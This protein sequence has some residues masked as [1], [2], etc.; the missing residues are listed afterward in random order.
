MSQIPLQHGVFLAPY[1]PNEE[2]PTTWLRRDIELAQHLDKLGFAELWVGE[3]HSGGFEIIASPDLFIAAAA[4]VTRRIRFGTGVMT[5]PYHNPLVV[6]NR[7]AQLDHQTMGRVSFGFGPGLLMSDALMMGIDPEKTRDMLLEAIDV[8]VRLLRGESVTARTDWFNL[9]EARAHL[10]PYSQP[11]EMAVASAG[12]PSGG[13][14][15]GKFGMSML[16]VAASQVGA[17]DVL[18][19]NWKIA[20]EVAAQYGNTMDPAKLR[21]VAPVHIA[22]TREKALENVRHGLDRW[23]RY[24]DM[25]SPNP[26]PKDGRDPVDILIDSGRAVIGTPEDAIAMIERL[27]G[28]QGQFG[29]F[30]AQHVD[31]ADWDQTM[32]SFELYARYVMPHFSGANANRIATYNVMAERVE[33]FKALRR[34]AADKA[35]AQHEAAPRK[36]G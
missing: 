32:K 18:A 10:L 36:V 2:S 25:A 35:F 5:L 22:E 15:A 19:S 4:E 23:V 14:A 31:W 20:N 12:T 24:Y 8:I 11:L 34:G 1:H 3:H 33:E 26:F 7:I 13:R 9:V 30:L 17:F 6:A 16:C 21:L 29:V 27:R 28:K